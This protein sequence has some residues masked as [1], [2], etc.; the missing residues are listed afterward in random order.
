MGAAAAVVLIR[1][2]RVV[3]AF[4]RAGA[5][6]PERATLPSDIG[7][8]SSGIGWRRLRE[9]AVVRETPPDSGHYYLDVEVWRALRRTR[10]RVLAAVLIVAVAASLASY[11]G[12]LR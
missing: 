5:T 6:S 1:E 2:R 9:R 10:R 7:V 3:D 4:Q 11:F 12:A 8:E